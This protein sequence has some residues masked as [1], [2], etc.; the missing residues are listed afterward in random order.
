M[1]RIVW[2]PF[3][4][5]LLQH[6]QNR[7]FL[8]YKYVVTIPGLSTMTR[9][10]FHT[11]M[12]GFMKDTLFDFIIERKDRVACH[13]NSPRTA[14]IYHIQ[15]SDWESAVAAV[16]GIDFIEDMDESFNIMIRNFLRS[17]QEQVYLKDLTKS[18]FIHNYPSKENQSFTNML[19]EYISPRNPNWEIDEG[20]RVAVAGYGVPRA[21]MYQ[22]KEGTL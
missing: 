18:C 13:P 7:G 10:R 20:I 3:W 14:T 11:I 16:K 8:N 9:K 12:Q 2:K 6:M 4:P 17:G 5:V 1:P 21:Y 19:S 22:H 15:D